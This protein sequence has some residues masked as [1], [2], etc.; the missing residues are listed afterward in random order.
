[1]PPEGVVVSYYDP[2]RPSKQEGGYNR[3]GAADLAMPY[4]DDRSN[5]TKKSVV[6]YDT[7]M[8][9]RGEH[10]SYDMKEALVCSL[11]GQMLL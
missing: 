10:N 1:M 8:K 3:E 2:G 5:T 4:S 7:H 9:Y 11:P 6:R